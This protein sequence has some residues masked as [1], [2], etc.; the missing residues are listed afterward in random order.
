METQNEPSKNEETTFYQDF[1]L[2]IIDQAIV[3]INMRFSQ[4]KSFN[5][6][7]GFLYRI[8]KIKFME[9]EELRKYCHD[10]QNILTGGEL[11]D[12]DCH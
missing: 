11:K 2:T 12:I 6:N 1:F 9:K 5:N 10:I 7:F 3:S 8:S 4:L